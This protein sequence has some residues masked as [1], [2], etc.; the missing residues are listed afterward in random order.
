MEGGAFQQVPKRFDIIFEVVF[1]EIAAHV[2]N[3][4]EGIVPVA[5]AKC[6]SL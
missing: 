6:T 2:L 4:G 5:S 1:P 3:G